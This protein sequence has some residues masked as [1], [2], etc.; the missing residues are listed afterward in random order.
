MRG[1]R[2]IYQGVVANFEASRDRKEK[3]TFVLQ[4]LKMG[5]METACDVIKNTA[6]EAHQ[7]RQIFDAVVEADDLGVFSAAFKIIAKEDPNYWVTHE[8][9]A[10]PGGPARFDSEPL[11]SYAINKKDEKIALML[12]L[13]PKTDVTLKG[14]SV[15]F[16]YT[17]GMFMASVQ[18]LKSETLHDDAVQLARKAGMTDLAAVLL[19][20]AAQAATAEADRLRA[21]AHSLKP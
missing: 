19:E 14:R 6:F 2:E 1:L 15:K 9:N 17:S 4:S 10:G 16:D 21:E 13:N 12:A 8:H 3:C 18:A 5:Y 20:R 7:S 11:L